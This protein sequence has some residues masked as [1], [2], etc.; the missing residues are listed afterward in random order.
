MNENM[1]KTLLTVI[2]IVASVSVPVAIGSDVIDRDRHL[3]QYTNG[4]VYDNQ[5]GLEWYPGPD[6]ATSWEQARAWIAGLDVAGGG[7][8]MPTIKELDTL[9]DVGDGINNITYLM[10]F[11]GFW[12]WSGDTEGRPKKWLFS[13]SYGGEGWN[14]Q[15]PPEGGRT[16][17][18]RQR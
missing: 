18:V 5:S 8:R 11:S 3:V 16:A 10:D 17:A 1:I 15:P 7:W 12:I 2:V 6:E 4:V 9:Y 13:F 14:G